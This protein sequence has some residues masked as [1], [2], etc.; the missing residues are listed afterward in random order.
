MICTAD[1]L[2]DNAEAAFI[3]VVDTLNPLKI[4]SIFKT[5]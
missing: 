5:P 4:D 1:V 3:L 2:H